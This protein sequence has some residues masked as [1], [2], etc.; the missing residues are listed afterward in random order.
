[1]PMSHSPWR[2]FRRTSA[3]SAVAVALLSTGLAGT[4]DAARTTVSGKVTTAAGVAVPGVKVSIKVGRRQPVVTTTN[5]SGT[6]SANVRTGN[7]KISLVGPE[8]PAPGLPPTWSFKRI[9]TGITNNRVL[10][11][12]LPQT[13][14][15]AVTVFRSMTTTPI[16]G[17][18]IKQC[19]AST[20]AAD[21]H[22]V[23]AGS[24]A[25]APRQNF[26]GAVTDSAG[27]VVLK[28]FRDA[29]LG[30][31]CAGFVESTQATTTYAARGPIKD[32]TSN[33]AMN[34]YAPQVVPQAGVVSDSTTSG[35]AGVKVAMRS[36]GGQVDSVSAPTSASGDFL[37]E[38]AA[39]TV[40]AR[41]SSRALAGVNPLSPNIPRSFK[42]TVDGTADGLSPWVVQ[43]PATVTLTVEVMNA[44]GT[45][46]KNAAIRPV[47]SGVLDKANSA[48]L[49]AGQPDAQISQLI[50]GDGLS[51][52]TGM[53]SARLFPDSALGAFTVTKNVG[54]GARR[55]ATVPAGTVLTSNTQ[56][57]V[58]LP[59]A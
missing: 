48:V 6:F 58:V 57:T 24:A 47:T 27:Q 29:T 43:L 10:N 37:T 2:S 30:R 22:V 55:V 41:F 34:I 28:S 31:L 53:M 51:N 44:N 17:A 50:Y 38:I 21:P 5:T 46:V 32:A 45:P 42:A 18:T 33:I 23:L 4:A 39:G 8:T 20:S 16:P 40:F 1:M 25:V 35:A 13:S 15:V 59:P 9:K 19:L 52:D 7:A 56:I 14:N 36:A 54:G 11:F 3:V 49:V 26:G 12:S